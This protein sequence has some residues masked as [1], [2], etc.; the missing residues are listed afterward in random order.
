MDQAPEWDVR[1]RRKAA[2]KKNTLATLVVPLIQVDE[3][4]SQRNLCGF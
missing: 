3:L 4:T 2:G 1:L